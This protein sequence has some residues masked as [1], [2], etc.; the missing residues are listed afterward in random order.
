[1]PA[2]A[3]NVTNTVALCPV[4]WSDSGTVREIKN[5]K[6]AFAFS[7]GSGR[8]GVIGGVLLLES[9]EKLFRGLVPYLIIWPLYYWR[10]V[11]RCAKWLNRNGTPHRAFK[12]M[13]VAVIPAVLLAAVYGGYF[14]AGLSVILLAILDFFSTIRSPT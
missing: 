12:I 9:G 7:P 2:V 1:M 4:I 11:N 10:S 5:Q 6:N 13:Q 3:A 14:G 8:G